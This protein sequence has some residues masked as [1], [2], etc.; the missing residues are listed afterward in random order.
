LADSPAERVNLR[1]PYGVG[2]TAKREDVASLLEEGYTV[3]EPEQT[4]ERA[5]KKAYGDSP[6]KAGAAAF[7]NTFT[8]GASDWARK[9]VL[10]TSAEQI[11]AEYKHNPVF[12]GLGTVGAFVTPVGPLAGLLG[13]AGNAARNA[14]APTV[15]A[16]EA[17]GT[18]SR[19]AAKVLP[20]VTVGAAEGAAHGGVQAVADVVLGDKPIDIQRM[21][22]AGLDGMWGGAGWGAVGG[23]GGAGLELGAGAA[24]QGLAKVG[25]KVEGMKAT[26][27]PSITDEAAEIIARKPP[28]LAPAAEIRAEAKVAGEAV[29]AE[30]AAVAKAR[31][32]RTAQAEKA[33]AEHAEASAKWTAEAEAAGNNLRSKYE[34]VYQKSSQTVAQAERR[35]G[36]KGKDA[37]ADAAQAEAVTVAIAEAKAARAAAEAELGFAKVA[38]KSKSFTWTDDAAK[39]FERVATAE[40]AGMRAIRRHEDAMHELERV[41]NPAKKWDRVD[42]TSGLADIH[43]ARPPVAPRDVFAEMPPIPTDKLDAAIAREAK[44]QA[45]LTG[46]V[47]KAS[48]NKLNNE[49]IAAAEA[50]GMKLTTEQLEAGAAARGYDGIDFAALSPDAQAATKAQLYRGALKAMKKASGGGLDSGLVGAAAGVA[51]DWMMDGAMGPMMAAV[52][53]GGG[54]SRLIKGRMFGGVKGYMAGKGLEAA[55]RSIKVADSVLGAA[56]KGAKS[57]PRAALAIL[58]ATK[59]NPAAE[60]EP[61]AKNSA[62]AFKRVSTQLAAAVADPQ[63]TERAIHANLAPAVAADVSVGSQLVQLALKRLG[64]LYDKMP[65]DPGMRGPFERADYQ[66][67]DAELSSFARCVA[68]ADDPVGQL[69]Q[70]MTSGMLCAE[71]VETVKALYPDIY[72]HIKTTLV[73]QAATLTESLPWEKQVTLTTFFGVP[74]NQV[75]RPEMVTQFQ[76]TF[77]ARDEQGPGGQPQGKPRPS[78]IQKPEPTQAQKLASG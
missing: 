45:L 17:G 10:G 59:V 9:N 48:I 27:G 66:P 64:W 53:G 28:T 11:D 29:E 56:G 13:K 42:P 5:V 58:N 8:F 75:L 6:A 65:K 2:G 41:M 69:Q 1:D 68:A 25:A 55:E 74:M 78:S 76:A 71:T 38:G 20:H 70:E 26:R 15:K 16:L 22:A 44:I 51:V 72:N 67:S 19:V 47:K 43:A 4:H 23:L 32:E 49:S 37:I 61:K 35:L 40:S 77:A 18:A 24:R 60:D 54:M 46:D 3:E 52:L 14:I 73:E 33:G 36:A 50:A 31:G 21:V 57:A 39:T 34:D 62:E 12:T 30:T 7:A 63:G